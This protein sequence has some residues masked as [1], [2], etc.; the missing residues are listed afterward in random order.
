MRKLYLDTNLRLVFGVTLMVVLSVSSIMPALPLMIKNL[1]GLTATSVGLVITTFTLPGVFLTPVAGI[2]GDRVGRKKILVPSLFLF[3]VAGTACFF[4]SDLPT[5]LTLRF[6][7]GVGAAPLGVL[8]MTLIGDLY[9]DRERI[10]AMGLN[11]S[12][13]SMGTALFP[14]IGGALA[15]LG[16]QWPFLLPVVAIPLGFLVF[17]RLDNPEPKS[18]QNFKDYIKSS[19]A[20]MR[21]RQAL[22]LFTATLLTFVILYGPMVTYLPILMDKR[23]GSSPMAIGGIFSVASFVTALAASQLGRLSKRFGEA[24]ML[25]AAFVLYIPAMLLL[26]LAPNFWLCSVPIV[27][28]GLAQGLNIPSAMTLLAGLAPMESRGAFMAANGMVLRLAQTIA[29]LLMG[30]VLALWGMDAVFIAG[31]LC[32]VLMLALAFWAIK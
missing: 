17:L 22:A 10:T 18:A 5:L 7:Q 28:F 20:Q 3:G 9:K 25:R 14:A 19:L 15:L 11:A 24:H 30:G 23:F 31:A 13:L 26:P 12:V 1:P 27:L 2:L 6:L 16:W 21:S 4:A 32:S 8:N 29:P